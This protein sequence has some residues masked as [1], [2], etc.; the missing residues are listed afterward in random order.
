MNGDH[1]VAI[2][3]RDGGDTTTYVVH[4]IP[5]DFPD[6]KILLKTE[7]VSDGLLFV[8]TRYGPHGNYTD[9]MAILDN[10]GVPRFHR[11]N[12]KNF[13]PH[14]D[15]PLVDGRRVR[16]SVYHSNAVSL[17]DD[18][19]DVIRMVATVEGVTSTDSHDFLIT[20]D[21]NFVFISYHKATRDLS[22]F[23][24]SEGNP[25]SSMEYVKDSVIQE[26]S[27]EGTEEFLWNSWDHLKLDPDCRVR[28]GDYA[29]LNSLQLVD[30][31]IVAS[32]PRCSQVVR[33]DF[34]RSEGTGKLE[35]KLGGTSPTR[36]PDTEFLEIVDDD[37][38]NNEFCGQHHATLTDSGT[39]MLFDNGTNC[40]G[41]RKN[42]QAFTRVVEYR[43]SSGTQAVLVREYPRPD[44][45]GYSNAAG[46]VTVLDN[47]NWLIT[48][49]RI[50][51]ATANLEEIMAISEVDPDTGTA[52]FRLH[53]S[54]SNQL[55]RSY[56]VY[57]EPEASVRIPPNLP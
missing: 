25:Y 33:I 31:D 36:D 22:S 38:A 57:R 43:I 55:A 16:Y 30:G 7:R 1:D 20:E 42:M 15:G 35:W 19:F 51:G 46:G 4:C 27:P 3:L 29:H 5:S 48:W 49:G 9:F 24:D 52:H 23:T 8:T 53:M 56:R 17:L 11:K 6:I 50:T 2:E 32:F 54:K 41:A 45:Q 18:N 44:G 12:G 40:L 34:D 28:P 37:D 21:D 47:G 39:V 14:A 13:R 10:N 26:V